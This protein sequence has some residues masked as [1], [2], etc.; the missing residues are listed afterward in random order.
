MARLGESIS[1]AASMQGQAKNCPSNLLPVVAAAIIYSTFML[2]DS[3][4]LLGFTVSRDPF[5]SRYVA[6]LRNKVDI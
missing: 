5:A 1:F 2:H 3:R 6:G 4:V